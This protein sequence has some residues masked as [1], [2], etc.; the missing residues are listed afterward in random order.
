M[1]TN[2]R[3]QIMILSLTMVVVMLG[4]GLVI[5]IFPFYIEK[6]GAS[7]SSFGLLVAM[8][9]LTEL[10]FGPLWGSLSDRVGRK[11]VLLIGVFGVGLSLVLMGLSTQFWMLLAARALSGI[12]SAATAAPALAYISD[13]SSEKERGGGIGQLGAA[14]EAGLI[15]GPGLGGW[16]G[17]VSLSLPF[18]VAAGMALLT[19]LL[20]L[21]LLP[22]SLPPEARRSREEQTGVSRTAALRQVVLSP[23][24]LLL[25]LLLWLSFGLTNFDAMFSLFAL[26]KYG[27][28]PE[29]VGV[30]TTIIGIMSVLGKGLLAGPL[31]RRWGDA[32][33]VRV[34]ALAV[35]L[36]FVALLLANSY[37]TVL[38]AT[39]FFVMTKTLLRPAL[40]AL[41][42]KRAPVGHGVAM[43]LG[44]STVSLGR[45]AGSVWGGFMFDLDVDYPYLTGVGIM[46][47][48]F[49]FSL[50]CLERKGHVPGRAWQG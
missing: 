37:A 10:I 15:V 47:I 26:E 34:S 6:M 25:F 13:S 2:R 35:S 32:S 50:F 16:L 31:T 48:G 1:D 9:A 45:I 24:G 39:A 19:L 46:L 3:S 43:G 40:F 8:A 30:I 36:G 33:I 23:V 22:E 20:I 27:Y 4:F 41:I 18:F 21:F 5:P 17:M 7:G 28:G 38:L 11:P 14:M 12:L 44:N 49:L 29:R 42:S